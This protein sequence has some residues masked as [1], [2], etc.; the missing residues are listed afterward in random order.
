MG[1]GRPGDG[2]WWFATDVSSVQVTWRRLPPGRTTIEA[3]GARVELDH[4]GGPGAVVLDGLPAGRA[5]TA[6]A[7][8]AQGRPWRR[9][10][11]TLAPPPGRELFRFATIS[12]LHVGEHHFGFLGTI[13][14][15]AQDQP[16][17]QRATEAAVAEI[18]DWGAQLLV[19]KGDMTRGGEADE[20][21]EFARLVEPFE[22][23]VLATPGN[24]DRFQPPRTGWRRLPGPF[25]RP[26]GRH[27]L[28]PDDGLTRVGL[29]PRP[30]QVHD[31]D[32]LRI[33]LVDTSMD[34][35][36]TGQ[37]TCIDDVADAV[38]VDRPAF[39]VLH[40]QLM[41]TSTPT[42]LPVGVDHES[43]LRF[44]AALERANPA[45]FVTC[46]HTHRHRRH[47]RG[48]VVVTEVGSTKDF[49]GTWAGYVV[50][51]G[52]IRQVVRRVARP[53]VLAWT[54]RTT[55]AAL[56]AWGWW[57]P[58]RRGDRCFSHPWPAQS[59]GQAAQSKGQAAQSKG[60]AAGSVATRVPSTDQPG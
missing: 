6:R 20:W 25:S 9:R 4:P 22:G 15:T 54:D 49:P 34:D 11:R 12:D 5:T 52:G 29:D 7:R 59:R 10:V 13:G 39:V 17:P 35:R 58:G 28:T 51:E 27:V 45:T 2:L 40:H 21:D 57:S 14:E 31:V 50:H 60:Q 47:V 24:H 48:S 43:S 37:L 30:L 19:V 18:E 8:P 42:Y 55:R 44:L 38:A 53:D 16:H 23:P 46:G 1:P 32:G 56:G 3:G 26:A 36:R 41:V 33:V